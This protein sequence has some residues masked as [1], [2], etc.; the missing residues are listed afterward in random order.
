M[1]RLRFWKPDDDKRDPAP[2]ASALFYFGP[3]V[4]KFRE[5]FAQFG[6]VR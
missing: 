1:G 2:F 5:A 4:P 3:D 6:V